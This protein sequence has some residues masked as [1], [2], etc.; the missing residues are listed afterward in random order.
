MGSKWARWAG[1]DTVGRLPPPATPMA[2]PADEERTGA[3]VRTP[4]HPCEKSPCPAVRDLVRREDLHHRILVEPDV[5]QSSLVNRLTRLEAQ[6]D[7]VEDLLRRAVSARGAA[8][9]G[10]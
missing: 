9:D 7:R 8:G 1:Q 3:T 2:L 5:G 10:A 4:D 6:L